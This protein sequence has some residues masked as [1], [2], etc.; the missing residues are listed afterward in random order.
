RAP[1][2]RRPW[3]WRRRPRPR[4]RRRRGAGGGAPSPRSSGGHVAAARRGKATA[5]SRAC[6][7]RFPVNDDPRR[8]AARRADPVVAATILIA[9]ELRVLAVAG[10][11]SYRY[12]DSID[13]ETLDFTGGSRRPW[14]TP[15]LYRMF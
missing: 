14:V 3:R 15:L 7:D 13:Y 1:T 9:A 5:G 2:R 4:P 10:L 12:V 8:Q 11:R 6:D